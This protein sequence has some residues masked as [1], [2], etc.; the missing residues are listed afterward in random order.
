MKINRF[1]ALTCAAALAGGFAASNGSAHAVDAGDR[2]V[3]GTVVSTS[4]A[5]WAIQV[6]NTT[7]SA[8]NNQWCSGSL[9]AP[10]KV[11]TAAHCVEGESASSFSLTQGS[12]V[13]GDGEGQTSGASDIWYDPDYGYGGGDVAVITLDTP[14]TGV[15]T[16]PL[17][18]GTPADGS[19]VTVYGY[20]ETEGTGPD[21]T[22]QKVTVPVISDADCAD[23]GSSYSDLDAEGEICAGL[24]QGGKDSCQGDSG[25]PLV[26]NGKVVGVVSWG[27]GCADAGNPGVYAD[28]DTFKSLIEAQL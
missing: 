13:I 21:Q 7:S 12:D 26:Q 23:S 20:G 14:F 9:I 6:N 27:I 24:P 22:L 4:A 5:P 11:L 18:T 16:L 3:G 28:V 15:E 1:H 10:D 8:P 25:G 17:S 19:N 2:V